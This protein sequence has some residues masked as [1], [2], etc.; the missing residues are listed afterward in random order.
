M[1][2]LLAGSLVCRAWNAVCRR[3]LWISIGPRKRSLALGR[4]LR[5]PHETFSKNVRQVILKEDRKG[6]LSQHRRVL[7][8]LSIKGSRS[9]GLPSHT[10]HNLHPSYTDTIPI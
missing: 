8:L 5:S 9:N 4:L 1:S 7:R 10:A 2:T 3:R 6:D